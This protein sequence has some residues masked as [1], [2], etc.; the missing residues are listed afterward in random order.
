MKA[1][2]FGTREKKKAG[3]V[4]NLL[5]NRAFTIKFEKQKFD[6]YRGGVF[7]EIEDFFYIDQL[8]KVKKNIE[9]K[10]IKLDL[11]SDIC[12]IILKCHKNEI[13]NIVYDFVKNCRG[14]ITSGTVSFRKKEYLD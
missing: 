5:A 1:L 14:Y 6:F 3:K 11:N 12:K 4:A 2:N 8:N 13:D 7:R 10:I 9:F